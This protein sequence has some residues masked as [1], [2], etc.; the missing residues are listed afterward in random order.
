MDFETY[1]RWDNHRDS[2]K[3]LRFL[4]GLAPSLMHRYLADASYVN[5]EKGAGPSTSMA[6]YLCAGVAATE[7]IKILLR[8]GK[9]TTVPNGLHFDA[10]LGKFKR[11]WLPMGNAN[12]LQK[13]RLTVIRRIL[14]SHP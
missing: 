5:L 8:R 4:V 12:P 13:L 1:F 10:Y 9:L 11:T 2:E 3:A 14:N 7:A 6:C